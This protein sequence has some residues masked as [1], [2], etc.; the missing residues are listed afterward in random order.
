MV[1]PTEPQNKWHVDRSLNLAVL[2]ALGSL[3]AT[4]AGAL[5]AGIWFASSQSTRLTT[6]EE[7]VRVNSGNS[8]R[9]IRVET[10]I[11]AIHEDVKDIKQLLRAPQ[12]QR[13]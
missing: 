13:R 9:I 6:V 1:P 11:G 8:E 5:G 4:G 2:L 7:S 12:D 10:Q 3:L